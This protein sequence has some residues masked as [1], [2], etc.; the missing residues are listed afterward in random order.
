M[1]L[2]LLL[3]QV[4]GKAVKGK[5]CASADDKRLQ[6]QALQRY[7]DMLPEE[8]AAGLAVDAMEGTLQPAAQNVLAQQ[9]R[10]VAALFEPSGRRRCSWF[11]FPVD[12]SL[13]V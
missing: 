6:E 7:D 4:V 13:M 1:N 5:C 10:R 11:N 3:P 12:S 9:L 8:L 2:P